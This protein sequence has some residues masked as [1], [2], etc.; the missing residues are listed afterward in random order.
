ME[1]L[2]ISCYLSSMFLKMGVAEALVGLAGYAY[3][4][5]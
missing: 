2:S 5:I 4:S 1:S 3:G